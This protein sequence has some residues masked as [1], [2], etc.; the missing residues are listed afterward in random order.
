MQTSDKKTL[1]KILSESDIIVGFAS[2]VM[3]EALMLGK[4]PIVI[5]V[6]FERLNNV[7]YKEATFRIQK[8]G[9][10]ADAITRLL[11]NAD[12]QQEFKSARDEYLHEYFDNLDGGASFRIAMLLDR[13]LER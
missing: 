13:L 12:L 11:T 7:A 6:F 10:V 2:T 8:N 4:T 1:Y 5:E 9:N 3:I